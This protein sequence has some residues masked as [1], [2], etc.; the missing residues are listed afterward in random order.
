MSLVSWA[1]VSG[2]W[3]RKEREHP[4]GFNSLLCSLCHQP[5][6]LETCNADEFGKAVH[7]QCYVAKVAQGTEQFYAPAFSL[8]QQL[9]Q[10]AILPWHRGASLL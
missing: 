2:G 9:Q 5:V 3:F 7:E 4:R 10:D 8:P 6:R 1:H